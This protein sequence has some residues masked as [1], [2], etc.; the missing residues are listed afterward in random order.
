MLKWNVFFSF[1]LLQNDNVDIESGRCSELENFLSS[2]YS[3]FAAECDWNSMIFQN[4]WNLGFL[5][6][7][8]FFPEKIFEFF[9]NR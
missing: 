6:K 4:V 5:N 2:I 8:D 7:I 9:Q 3:K 1:T